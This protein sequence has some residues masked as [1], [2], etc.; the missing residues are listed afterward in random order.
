MIERFT[1]LMFAITMA[2]CASTG[3]D[4]TVATAEGEAAEV[5][6]AQGE[7]A[8]ATETDVA[9]ETAGDAEEQA[10]AAVAAEDE[11]IC[12]REK[13]AGSNFRRK[14]CVKRSAL[15]GR[16]SQDQ[17]ALRQMRSLSPSSTQEFGSQ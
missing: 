1:V 6:A 12:R 5:E 2:A 7:E 13:T 15:E 3:P 11:I 17:E 9:L 8:T 14:I 16:A 4:T 10:V